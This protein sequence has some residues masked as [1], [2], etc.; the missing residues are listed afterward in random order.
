[1]FDWFKKKPK[2]PE[3]SRG[4]S[5]I[6]RYDN[7]SSPQ[8]GFSEESTQAFQQIR[9]SAYDATFGPCESVSHELVPL[10]PHIDV[11]IYPPCEAKDRDFYTLITGGMSDVPMTLE[12]HIDAPARAELVFYC[13]EPKDEYFHLLRW[14]ARF[15]HDYK[16]WLGVGH[17]LP[18]G[19]P[20]E[21]LPPSKV[22]DTILF[23]PTLLSTDK[24]M[25]DQLHLDGTPIELLW[26]VPLSTAECELKLNRGTDAILDLFDQ[27]EH[28]FV[29]DPHRQ[30]YV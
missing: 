9:E 1:L 13:T 3:T 8:F 24:E 22:L 7:P 27:H 6:L 26:V 5:K 14:L 23:L 19:D 21:P 10:V 12:R 20:P 29:Y 25:A 16:T 28:P 30:S 15:P 4:G 18:N 2:Q 11:Y 17:T